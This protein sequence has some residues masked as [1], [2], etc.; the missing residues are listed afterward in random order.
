MQGQALA[1]C[2][3]RVFEPCFGTG[4]LA[5][6]A[7]RAFERCFGTG[8]LVPCA[9]DTGGA[10]SGLSD[11]LDYFYRTI[12]ETGCRRFGAGGGLRGQ[13]AGSGRLVREG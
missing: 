6:C 11:Y 9:E 4:A 1:P 8:A 2:A 7:G 3:G 5:P 10:V 12:G 13:A